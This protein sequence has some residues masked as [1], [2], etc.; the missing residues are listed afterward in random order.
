MPVSDNVRTV[1]SRK[2]ARCGREWRADIA[3]SFAPAA[4]SPLTRVIRS[5]TLKLNSLITDFRQSKRD[6]RSIF[7]LADLRNK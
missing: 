4:A 2:L 5:F 1:R 6:H 3:A 7:P